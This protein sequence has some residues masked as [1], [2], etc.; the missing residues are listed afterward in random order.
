MQRAKLSKNYR[1]LPGGGGGG[2]GVLHYQDIN[3]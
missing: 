3:S 2:G 1:R